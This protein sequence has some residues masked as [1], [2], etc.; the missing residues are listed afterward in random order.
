MKLKKIFLCALLGAVSLL[1]SNT[2]SADNCRNVPDGQ[3]GWVWTCDS[4]PGCHSV[5]DGQGG[6]V[7]ICN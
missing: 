3:G 1:V 2:S 7:W 5:P 4:T 6:W